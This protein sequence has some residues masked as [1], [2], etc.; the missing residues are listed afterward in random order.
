MSKPIMKTT[1]RMGGLIWFY[2]ILGVSL[3]Y[4]KVINV[5]NGILLFLATFSFICLSVIHIR[6][7]YSNDNTYLVSTENAE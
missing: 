7:T 1:K 5:P 3:F 4:L 2:W 6:M